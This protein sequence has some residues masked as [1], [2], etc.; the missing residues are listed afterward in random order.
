[1]SPIILLQGL[2]MSKKSTGQLWGLELHNRF[3]I[4]YVKLYYIV[5]LC[6]VVQKSV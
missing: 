4:L 5:K 1:M 2:L 3:T 6:S